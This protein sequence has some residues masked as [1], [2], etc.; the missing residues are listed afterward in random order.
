ML[1][2]DV[3]DTEGA[4]CREAAMSWIK[5]AEG[6]LRSNPEL[7]QHLRNLM[8]SLFSDITFVSLK[9]AQSYLP[10]LQLCVDGED[11]RGRHVVQCMSRCVVGRLRCHFAATRLKEI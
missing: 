2:R 9:M 4:A 5:E 1:F 11:V 3:T 10:M 7:R 8:F 6:P